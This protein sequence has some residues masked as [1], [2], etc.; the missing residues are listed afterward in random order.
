VKFAD[1]TEREFSEGVRVSEVTATLGNVKEAVAVKMEG[2]LLDL[3][4]HFPSLLSDKCF[5]IS[6]SSRL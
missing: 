1:G 6:F 4:G 2:R 3:S 5:F